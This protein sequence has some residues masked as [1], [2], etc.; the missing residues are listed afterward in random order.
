M[1]PTPSHDFETLDNCFPF[2]DNPCLVS[3]EELARL[4]KMESIVLLDTRNPEEY[5]E[6][7]IP[8]AVNVYDVFTYLST[9]ENGGYE[10]MRQHFARLF[11]QAGVDGS[12]WVV[13]YE[14]AMDNGYGR[15]CRGWFIL[16]HLGLERVRVL[17]GG[18]L[19]WLL[20][21]MPVTPALP[22]PTP[23]ECPVHPDHSVIVSAEEMLSALDDPD[24]VKLDGRDRS[25]WVGSTSSPYSTDFAPRKGRIP[26]S[27]WIEW[28]RLMYTDR[29]GVTWFKTPAELRALF[30]EVGITPSSTVYLYC[31]KG[32]R[33]STLFIALKLA[34]VEKVRNYF[35]SWN[36][37]S[38]NPSLPIETG[39]PRPRPAH[40]APFP[41]TRE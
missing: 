35:G 33:T 3:V 5:A 40:W 1:T 16:R 29:S 25:E 4:Q 12:Q 14:D 7:H 39:Y 10:A 6:D 9:P 20:K 37:W 15:S 38:R 13:V 32:A 27:V 30:A 8:G 41:K 2:P 34:G 11:G 36:E 26:N 18:Y 24:I 28:F 31:F 23:V 19:A 21:D 22:G 17:H